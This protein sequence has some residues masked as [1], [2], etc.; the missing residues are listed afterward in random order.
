MNL[1]H[2]TINYN[3]I[4]GDIWSSSAR[5]VPW[6][7]HN[8]LGEKMMDQNTFMI[9]LIVNHQSNLGLRQGDPE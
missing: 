4:P 1:V 6:F 7:C 9:Q 8:T 2:G 3:A 5:L